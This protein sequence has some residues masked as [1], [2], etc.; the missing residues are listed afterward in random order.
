MGYAHSLGDDL[1]G[2]ACEADIPD[3]LR[4]VVSGI[5]IQLKRNKALESFEI[6]GLFVAALDCNEQFKIR[7]RCCPECC[8]RETTI[9]GK[10]G[11][12][13]VTEYYH[14]QVYAQMSGPNFSVILD[15]EP[16][17]PG[18]EECQTA[19]RLL[20]R[21]R[22]LYG[23]RF[24]DV[25]TVDAWYP[26]GPFIRAVQQLGWGVVSVLKQERYEIYQET[27][28]L[29]PQ[30]KAERFVC[31]RGPQKREIC[32]QEVKDLSFSEEPIGPV[33]VVV[34]EEKWKENHRKGTKKVLEPKESHW[35]WVVT[36]ELDG[37]PTRVIW[38]IG[39]NRWGIENH[40]FNE[41]TQ[42][43]HLTYCP[44]HEPVAIIVWLLFLIIG[45][46]TFEAFARFKWQIA[47]LGK[48]HPSGDPAAALAG[49]CPLGGAP[50]ALERMSPAPRKL[51]GVIAL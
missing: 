22:N 5:V 37:H 15:L 16:V 30:V 6:S 29:L 1:L 3:D 42:F 32:L 11:P 21:I 10:D 7:H 8:V 31:D 46:V 26:K 13:K 4:D 50:T 2:D 49:Y 36:K 44:H 45:F 40:A 9:E 25:I 41:M 39:Y 19:I 48:S 43:C 28:A 38:D 24:F 23:P 12:E 20:T 47:S 33:R 51:Y 35:R 17:R 34:A 14:R 27:T 18:G